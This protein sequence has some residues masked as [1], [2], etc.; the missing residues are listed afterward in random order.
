[1]LATPIALTLPLFNLESPPSNAK[2]CNRK[3]VTWLVSMLKCQRL[4]TQPVGRR[5]TNPKDI[6]GTCPRSVI[7]PL[8]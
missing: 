8:V 4:E 1:V 6:E 5:M 7:S 2:H 3:E